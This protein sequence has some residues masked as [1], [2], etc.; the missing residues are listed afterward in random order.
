MWNKILSHQGAEWHELSQMQHDYNRIGTQGSNQWDTWGTLHCWLTADE[1]WFSHN[2]ALDQFSKNAWK[3]RGLSRSRLKLTERL[4]EGTDSS[5]GGDQLVGYWFKISDQCGRRSDQ[6]RIG[7]DQL[8]GRLSIQNCDQCGRQ[9]QRRI[10][11]NW[12]AVY[13]FKIAI[14]WSAV[15]RFKIS[16]QLVGR[17]SIQN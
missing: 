12:S 4:Q 14:N 7:G 13:R 2:P 8:V 15:Y 16:D 17:L 9:S 10:A 6:R 5:F 11:I 1:F 3:Q